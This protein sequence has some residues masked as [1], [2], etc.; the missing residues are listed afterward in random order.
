MKKR[1][2]ITGA[3]GMLGATLVETFQNNYEVFA[4]GSSSNSLEHIKNYFKFDLGNSNFFE[5][6]DWAKPDIVIHCAALTNGNYCDKNPEEALK[7]NGLSLKKIAETVS[8]RTHVIYISTDAVFSNSM[9]KATEDNTVKPESVYGKSKELGE[10]FLNY[11]D[12]NYTIVR[13]TIVGLN[14]NKNKQ[15]FAEWIINSSKAKNE[16]TL[17]EDVLF[18]PIS[19]WNF[20]E[21]L[22][23]I[24]KN[25]GLFNRKTFHVSGSEFCTK[26][27]FGMKLLN[28]LDL[29]TESVK[30]GK[31]LE[32]LGRA[33]RSTDQTLNCSLYEKIAGKKLPDLKKTIQEIKLHYNEKY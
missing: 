18:N 31:I 19:I 28:E 14:R 3:T 2:L 24:A 26:Y 23:Y 25:Q 1:V 13:T 30:K 7:I 22:E 21:Q 33:K 11:S 17:F 6:I 20:A 29:P 12:I 16:I 5:L 15:G 10:F 8:K 27:D 4:T 32:F 9:H